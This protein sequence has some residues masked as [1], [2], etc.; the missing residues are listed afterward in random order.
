MCIKRILNSVRLKAGFHTESIQ[1]KTQDK[2]NIT[3]SYIE[4]FIYYPQKKS[5]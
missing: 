4:L 1:R 2:K 5:A 3:T